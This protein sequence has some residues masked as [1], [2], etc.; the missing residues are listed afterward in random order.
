MKD[1]FGN[2]VGFKEFFKRWREGIALVTPIQ[3]LKNEVRANFIMFTGYIV[4]LASLIIYFKKFVTPL[5]TIALLI[6]F[7]GAAWSS[8]IKWF[9]L[10]QQLKLFTELD[11]QAIDLNDID[12]LSEKPYYIK[13]K[14][15]EVKNG[16]R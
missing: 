4:G 7:L 11:T 3:R 5:F 10:R 6:I 13:N 16:H 15:K 8:G 2:K 1:R 12:K 9:A 14:K